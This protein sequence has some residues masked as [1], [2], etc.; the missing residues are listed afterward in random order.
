VLPPPPVDDALDALDAPGDPESVARALCLRALTR[1]AQT[2]SELSDLLRRRGV[3]DDAAAAVL[4]RFGE[5]GLI[6]DAALA[7][8]FSTAAHRERGLSRRAI[9]TRLRQRGVAAETIEAAV[10]P[11]DT[12]SERAAATA[13]AR[14]KAA[15]TAGLEPAVRLRRLVALLARRGYSS[16]LAFSVAREVLGGTNLEEL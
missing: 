7:A 2:R 5:V 11:I 10:E 8:G 14:R 4:D 1:R 6:D 16:G 3:P 9:T 12:A 13:L 15:T